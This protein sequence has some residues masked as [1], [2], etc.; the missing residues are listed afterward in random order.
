MRIIVAPDA[1]GA[2]RRAALFVARQAAR[3]VRARGRFALALSGGNTPL[4]MLRWLALE[5]IDW[6][7]VEL[8]QV[9]ERAAPRAGSERNLGTL[10]QQL[11]ARVPIPRAQVHP[12]PV[13]QPDLA[14]AAAA[15]GRALV[16]TLGEPPV[17]DLV[18]LGLGSDGHTASLMPGDAATRVA[19]AWASATAAHG[20]WRRMTLT[21]PAIDAA[22]RVLWLVCG[23]SKAAMLER[24]LLG[25][26]TIPAGLVRRDHACVVAD[27]A[28]AALMHWRGSA[29]QEPA[30]R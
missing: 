11:L 27:E 4:P 9:D 23:A 7:R 13:D 24:L 3:A 19:D 30:R 6:T 14:V 18:H 21:L 10:E 22:R 12:M 28:A 20:G 15:Y 5:S 2:A 1:E 17:L 29:A 8:F 25:D 26:R 16:G